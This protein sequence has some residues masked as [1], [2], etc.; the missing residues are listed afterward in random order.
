MAFSLLLMNLHLCQEGHVIKRAE[1]SSVNQATQNVSS[2]KNGLAWLGTWFVT[3]CPLMTLVIFKQWWCA[4][5]GI[6]SVHRFAMDRA[7]TSREKT[8]KALAN[9]DDSGC[10]NNFQIFLLRTPLG[11][12]IGFSTIIPSLCLYALMISSSNSYLCSSSRKVASG[13]LSG[14][15]RKPVW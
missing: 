13:A 14:L 7:T 11:R 5:L 9:M 12:I 3:F 6:V 1:Y 4:Y 2:M 8:A 15:L 10:S